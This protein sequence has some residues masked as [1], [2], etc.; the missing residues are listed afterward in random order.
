MPIQF[1][2]DAILTTFH[3]VN[4]LPSFILENKTPFELLYSKLQ[5]YDNLRVFGSFCFASTLFQGRRKFHFRARKC[6]FLGYSLGIKGYKLYDLTT[7][8]VFL[9][10]DVIVYESIFPFC[11]YPQQT[12]KNVLVRPMLDSH[13]QHSHILIVFLMLPSIMRIQ[14]FLLAIK[15]QT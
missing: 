2:R 5:S 13:F 4:R 3:L 12:T 6:I 15:T 7:R 10:R 8:Q 14:L 11:D 1:W 9:S